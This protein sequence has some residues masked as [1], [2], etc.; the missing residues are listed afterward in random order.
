M[1]DPLI[2]IADDQPNEML[3]LCTRAYPAFLPAPYCTSPGSYPAGGPMGPT[4][5]GQAPKQARKCSR[6]LH[7]LPE[8]YSLALAAHPSQ[9]WFCSTRNPPSSPHLKGTPVP[10]YTLR[11]RFITRPASPVFPDATASMRDDL[12]R[13]LPQTCADLYANALVASRPKGDIRPLTRLAE[14]PGSTMPMDGSWEA[15]GCKDRC[16]A[17]KCTISIA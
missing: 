1:Q 2:Y 7:K 15:L 13:V 10:S 9:R 17:V 12:G 14:K 5:W 11:Q 3:R 6:P 8:A 16:T 4:L